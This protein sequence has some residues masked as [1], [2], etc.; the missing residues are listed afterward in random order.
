MVYKAQKQVIHIIMN[1]IIIIVASLLFATGCLSQGYYTKYCADKELISKAKAWMSSGTWRNG[2]T[3]ASPDHSV[4]AVEFY[5]QYQ[6]NPQQWQALFKWLAKTD[7]LSLPKG[8]HKIVGTSLVASV[9]DDKNGSLETKRSESHYHHIDFQY[10]VKGVERFGL[11]DHYTSKANT[12]YKP[13]VIHYDYDVKKVHFIDSAPNKFF[14]F[15]PSDW[16]IAK[17]KTD[18]ND[19]DIRV[20]VIKVDY[21]D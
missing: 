1:R 13:D 18:L 21:R 10:V 15:F 12:K 20:V 16:H 2:F 6:K 11:I 17:V 5:Q 3:A 9:E 14:I 8:K 4:N 19:Q 7:L